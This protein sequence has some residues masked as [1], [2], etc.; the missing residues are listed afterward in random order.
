MTEKGFVL[1]VEAMMAQA[2]KDLESND[3]KIRRDAEQFIEKMKTEY[4][5]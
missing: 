2:Y 3:E 1:L 4:G 5:N